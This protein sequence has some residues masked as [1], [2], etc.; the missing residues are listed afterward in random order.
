MAQPRRTRGDPPE[1]DAPLLVGGPGDG[2]TPPAPQGAAHGDSAPPM[3]EPSA[4]PQGAPPGAPIQLGGRQY[5]VDPELAHAL[6][7]QQQQYSQ[8]HSRFDE[9]NSRYA[10]LESAL[11]PR[12]AAPEYDYNTKIFENPA[13]ALS[14]LKQEWRQEIVSELTGRYE[15]DQQQRAFWE[16]F[17]RAHPDLADEPELVQAVATRLMPRWQSEPASRAGEFAE[18]LAKDTRALILR[19][20]RKGREADAPAEP[21]P[22]GRAVVEG[23]SGGRAPTPPPDD[24][25]P[26]SLSDL[27]RQRQADRRRAASRAVEGG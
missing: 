14:R 9:L 25:G 12:Q 23:A 26:A 15:G 3:A 17:Y 5:T 18:A 2:E 21:R 4:P 27:L 13:E 10:R 19:V 7:R 8:L 16:G 6:E 24:E 20:S 22:A 1:G 11:M